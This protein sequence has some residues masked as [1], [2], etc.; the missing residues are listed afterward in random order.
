MPLKSINQFV[1]FLHYFIVTF[2]LSLS[3]SQS[4]S[5]FLLAFFSLNLSSLFISLVSFLS[6]FNSIHFLLSW[7][8]FP[9][10]SLS[11]SL[12]LSL[13]LSSFSILLSFHFRPLPW[14]NAKWPGQ[15]DHCKVHFTL[16]AP[17][18]WPCTQLS[19]IND[20]FISV[21][22]SLLSSVGWDSRIHR[23]NLCI[24]VRPHPPTNN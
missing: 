19:W 22:S 10:S 9:F 17:Y 20:Y 21:S 13:S 14:F 12:S 16:D 1:S 4:L 6:L 7:L 15:A 3:L 24:R 8:V 2:L 23:C 5:I 11:S 18:F